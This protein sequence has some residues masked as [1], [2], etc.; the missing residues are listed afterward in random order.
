MEALR[1]ADWQLDL[2]EVS[3]AEADA[4]ARR[5]SQRE[6]PVPVTG[7]GLPA[8]ASG[9]VT[10]GLMTPPRAGPAASSLNSPGSGV[11]PSRGAPSWQSGE[12]ESPGGL[13]ARVTAK[14]DP[15]TESLTEYSERV[16]KQATAL[17]VLGHPL[18]PGVLDSLIATAAITLRLSHEAPS[19]EAEVR[20][21]R[22]EYAY[23]LTEDDSDPTRR[24]KVTAL[25]GMLAERGVDPKD[26][27]RR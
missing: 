3:D 22:R 4:A 10:A 21:L 17:E 11:A 23:E 2:T 1:G 9:P 25:E 8:A 6:E 13:T 27:S 7:P 26:L 16:R 18:N 15:R 19:P 14:F 20:M 12:P 5:T 24:V